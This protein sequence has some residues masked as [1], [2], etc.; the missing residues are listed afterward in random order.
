MSN[1]EIRVTRWQNDRARPPYRRIA[2][3]T[4]RGLERAVVSSDKAYWLASAIEDKDP[5]SAT[6]LP[7]P[8]TQ[9]A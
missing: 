5:E 9:L 8:L 3:S 7:E 2:V 4:G 1:V 6:K